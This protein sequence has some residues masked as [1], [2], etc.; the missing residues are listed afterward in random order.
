MDRIDKFKSLSVAKADAQADIALINRFSVK[1]LTPEEVFC[2]SVILCDN[3]IDRDCERFTDETLET[4]AEMFVGKTGISD[5]YWS[6]ERQLARLYRS[7]VERTTEK[8]AL[9]QTLK[10]LRGIA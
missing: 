5:H 9:G 8:N 3:D 1:E 4:L 10:R 2:F 6:A 7:Q